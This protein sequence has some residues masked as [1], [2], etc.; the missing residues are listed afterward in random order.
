MT[1]WL[2]K[3]LW[4]M[5]YKQSGKSEVTQGVCTWMQ[6]CR[7]FWTLAPVAT[8][9][10][11]EIASSACVTRLAWDGRKMTVTLTLKAK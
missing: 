6:P 5:D 9:P 11:T 10:P 1:K 4:E 7:N 2:Y 3:Y 8:F